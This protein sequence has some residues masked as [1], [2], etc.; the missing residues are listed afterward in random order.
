MYGIDDAVLNNTAKLEQLLVESTAQ[1]NFKILGKIFHRFNPR[2]YSAILLI[3]ESHIAI[4]TYPE[5]HSLVFNL[6]SCRGPK[7]GRKTLEYF[8]NVLRPAKVALR[9]NKVIVKI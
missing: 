6:Y 4:H 1:E 2:G 8:K 5:Y 3:Q 7:D 9:E